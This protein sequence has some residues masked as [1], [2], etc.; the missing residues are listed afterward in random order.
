MAAGRRRPFP[1]GA[2][3]PRWTDA[4]RLLPPAPARGLLPRVLRAR[5]GAPGAGLAGLPAN[6]ASP[7]RLRS[8]AAECKRLHRRRLSPGARRPLFLAPED[9]ALPPATESAGPTWSDRTARRAASAAQRGRASAPLDQPAVGP[10]SRPE[11]RPRWRICPTW[12]AK[13]PHSSSVRRRQASPVRSGQGRQRFDDLLEPGSPPPPPRTRL[14]D[15]AG[16]NL[17][18]GDAPWTLFWQGTRSD[19]LQT[20]EAGP[21]RVFLRTHSPLQRPGPRFPHTDLPAR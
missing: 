10:E 5:L 18:P 20:Q 19:A 4:A 17:V 11:H 2:L 8:T 15:S 16:L 14:L 1:P 9:G 21:R 13:V 12:S 7:P 6:P 3:F